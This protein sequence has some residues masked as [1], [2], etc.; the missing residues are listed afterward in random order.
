MCGLPTEPIP[1][2]VFTLPFWSLTRTSD[3]LSLVVP[4]EAVH[5]NWNSEVG[6]QAMR[7]VGALDFSLVG[8]LAAIAAPL[9]QARISIFVLST[10]NTDYI[11]VKAFQMEKAVDALRKS[12]FEVFAPY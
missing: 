5:P 12:G 9:A 6:W 2:S 4:S 1:A 8:I 10:Y 7:I 11:L 3:E